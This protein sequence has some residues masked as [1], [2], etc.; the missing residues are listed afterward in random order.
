[1]TAMKFICWAG[2]IVA[3]P[4]P[5]VVVTVSVLESAGEEELVCKV[6]VEEPGVAKLLAE[7]EA[8]APE[9]R[10]ETE[11]VTGPVKLAMDVLERV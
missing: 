11:R 8:V 5:K 4:Q 3:P 7:T 2:S 6:R 9:G 10:P 1:M